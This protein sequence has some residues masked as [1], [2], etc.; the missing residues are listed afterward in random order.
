M[1]KAIIMVMLA[2]ATSWAAV[3]FDNANEDVESII[4][5][6]IS[7]TEPRTIMAWAKATTIPQTQWGT[8]VLIGEGTVAKA[9]WFGSGATPTHWEFS[10]WG[11]AYDYDTGVDIDLAWHHLAMTYD[12]GDYAGYIDGALVVSGSASI[13]TTDSHAFLSGHPVQPSLRWWEGMVD[14]AR[15]YSTALTSNQI[16]SIIID[17]CDR[18]VPEYGTNTTLIANQDPGFDARESNTNLVAMWDSDYL[19]VADGD[20]ITGTWHDATGNGHDATAV[21]NPTREA[22]R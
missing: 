10:F 6:G 13:N 8:V 4:N 18:F 16:A 5:T 1:H 17:T 11:G 21:N 15:I 7:G 20:A 9:M 3:E 2:A 14:D 22:A 19:P 12:G